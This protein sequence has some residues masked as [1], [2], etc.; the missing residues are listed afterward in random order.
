PP[1]ATTHTGSALPALHLC[2]LAPNQ[3]PPPA[4][5]R[6]CGTLPVVSHS[7]GAIA[8]PPASALLGSTENFGR[9]HQFFI[10]SNQ[11]ALNPVWLSYENWLWLRHQAGWNQLTEATTP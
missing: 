4:T 7:V 10:H 1:P 5:S 6:G 8:F 11:P 3:A 9:R 2:E